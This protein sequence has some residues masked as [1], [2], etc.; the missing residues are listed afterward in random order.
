L[1]PYF[2]RERLRF[3]LFVDEGPIAPDASSVPRT[4]W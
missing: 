4:T 3:A 2:E 1:T